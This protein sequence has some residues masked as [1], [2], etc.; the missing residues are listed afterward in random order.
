[1]ETREIG[2]CRAVRRRRRCKECDHRYTTYERI[3]PTK[4][5]VIK[6]GGTREEF[7]EEKIEKGMLKA[8]EKRPVSNARIEE[9]VSK[10]KG[11][12]LSGDETEI[13]SSIIGEKVANKLKDIDKVAY[14]RFASVYKEFKSVDSFEDEL[15]KIKGNENQGG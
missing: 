3:E 14:I 10:I 4:L 9:A 6:K 1:M 5:R 12:L 8:C 2:K 13:E 11:E 15:N 7:S